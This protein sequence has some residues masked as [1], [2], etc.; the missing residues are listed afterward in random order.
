MS[1][2]FTAL[3]VFPGFLLA[4]DG[5]LDETVVTKKSLPGFSLLPAGSVLQDVMIPRYDEQRKLTGALKAKM[6]TIINK[7]QVQG[8]QVTVRMFNPDGT[9]RGHLD[10]VKALFDQERGILKADEP[11]NI[12]S[13]RFTVKGSGL[14]YVFEQGQGFIKGPGTTTIKNPSP[15]AMFSPNRSSIGI[16]ALFGASIL[17]LISAV[18][19]PVTEAERNSMEADA[20]SRSA[21]FA[22]DNKAA[23]TSLREDLAA[24]SEANQAIEQFLVQ[25]DLEDE[26]T[27][28]TGLGKAAPIEIKPDASDTLV[29]CDGGIYFDSDEGVWVYLKN[30]RVKDPR[31]SLSGASELKIFFDK[32]PAEEATKSDKNSEKKRSFNIGSVNRIVA[33]GTVLLKRPASGE[34]PEI[35]ASGRMFTYNVKTEQ[36][37]IAGGAP[38]VVQG[39]RFVRSKSDSGILRVDLKSGEFS[40]DGPTESGLPLDQKKR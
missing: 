15:T 13:D 23:R 27:E 31:F 24:S 25:A 2:H 3:L 36:A 37:I 9:E 17:P 32:K 4:Q 38:W 18:P 10:L 30:V 14:V 33:T 11:V 7:T 16:S 34:D 29:E 1:L 40:F 26:T 6:M 28:D 20:R 22:V 39:R 12:V 19:T 21:E 35:Q 5:L 8:D